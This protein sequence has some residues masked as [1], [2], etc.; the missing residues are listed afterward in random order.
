MKRV[1]WSGLVLALVVLAAWAALSY[2]FGILTEQEVQAL[3]QRTSDREDF[4]LTSTEYRR[5]IFTS[6]ATATLEF[7]QATLPSNQDSQQ[8]EGQNPFRVLLEQQITHGPVP[9]GKLPQ[10]GS[11]MRPALG[12]IETKISLDPQTKELLKD[13]KLP[14]SVL[15]SMDATT[16][17]YWGGKGDTHLNV[18]SLQGEFGDDPRVGVD[19]AGLKGQIR[20]APDFKQFDGVFTSDKFSAAVPQKSTFEMKGMS[21]SFHQT[22]GAHGFYLGDLTYHLDFIDLKQQDAAKANEDVSLKGFKVMAL[23]QE[24]GHDLS[25]SA[26]LSLDQLISRDGVFRNAV[27]EL[28]LRKL[29]AR[30]LQ[31]FR[32]TVQQLQRE[33]AGV[34]DL[35]DR[36]LAALLTMLPRLLQSSPEVEIKQLGFESEDGDVRANALLKVDGKKVRGALSLPVLLDAAEVDLTVSAAEGVLVRLLKSVEKRD[37]SPEGGNTMEDRS[38]QADRD[39]AL[40]DA[41]RAQLADLTAQNLL[42][43]EKGVYKMSARYARGQVTLNGRPISLDQLLGQ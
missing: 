19:F 30:V 10:G 1:I 5:G 16:V 8:E 7:T 32:S 37:D 29:D 13:I 35:P 38:A 43:L 23:A 24:S 36:T 12:V 6:R 14:E 26:T 3:I 40:H 9:L 4:K 20:F 17:L 27:F 2:W 31:E 28:E 11:F 22:E 21:C 39:K 25:S 15:P 41:I 34:E 18:H 42:V 33:L